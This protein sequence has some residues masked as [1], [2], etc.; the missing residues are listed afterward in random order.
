M[1]RQSECFACFYRK[2][3]LGD[4]FK[5]QQEKMGTTGSLLEFTAAVCEVLPLNFRDAD[6]NKQLQDKQNSHTYISITA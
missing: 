4:V 2:F 3:P 1:G 5:K 6:V